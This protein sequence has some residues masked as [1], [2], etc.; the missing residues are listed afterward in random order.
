M[1][2]LS[3]LILLPQ[4]DANIERK[5]ILESHDSCR[6][7]YPLAQR[8]SLSPTLSSL[9]HITIWYVISRLRHIQAALQSN[10]SACGVCW[11]CKVKSEVAALNSGAF[12]VSFHLIPHLGESTSSAPAPRSMPF[13]ISSKENETA[14][15]RGL[16]FVKPPQWVSRRPSWQKQ[17]CRKDERNS[18]VQDVAQT[19]KELSDKVKCYKVLV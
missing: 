16:D 5:L 14:D 10:T 3:A 11:E 1:I 7:T 6:L 12:C 19:Q 13:L 17:H 15:H 4:Q 9:K 2:T 18:L 8:T